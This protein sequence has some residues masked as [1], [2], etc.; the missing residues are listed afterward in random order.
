MPVKAPFDP[1]VGF[2]R[3]HFDQYSP[4]DAIVKVGDRRMLQTPIDTEL[5]A[6]TPLDT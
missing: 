2:F 5:S 1:E 6:F 3:A 4:L